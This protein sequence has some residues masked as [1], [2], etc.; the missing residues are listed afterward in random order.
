MGRGGLLMTAEKKIDELFGPLPVPPKPLF[1][2][3]PVVRTGKLLFVS[4]QGPII[5]GK[6]MFTGKLGGEISTEQGY[7]AAKLCGVNLL[8]LLKQYL[9][10]L[11]RIKQV[12]NVK[13]YVASTNDFYDQ[14]KVANGLSDFLVNVLGD[15]G[16]HSRCALGMSVLPGNIPVE[17]E[18]T[19]EIEE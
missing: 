17:A 15:K 3:I 10:D 1:S 13:V 4:G 5:N 16:K 19:L 8:A 6:Q 18:M 2:Y 12:V 7:E 9:G 11:D 14:P